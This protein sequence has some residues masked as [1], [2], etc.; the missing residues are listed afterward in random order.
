MDVQTNV[1]PRPG[2]AKYVVPYRSDFAVP[3]PKE[4]EQHTEPGRATGRA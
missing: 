2:P 1:P 4:V 3:E